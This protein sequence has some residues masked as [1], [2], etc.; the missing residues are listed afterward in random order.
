M[1]DRFGLP[2]STDVVTAAE[3]CVEGID[4]LLEQSYGPEERFQQTLEAD[5]SFALAHALT[6]FMWNQRG[7]AEEARQ[8][9]AQAQTLAQGVSRRETGIIEAMSLWVN[10]K[11]PQALP[12]AKEHLAEYPRDMI[13][14][15][16]ANRLFTLG[17][18]GAGVPDFPV[19]LL[20]MVKSIEKANGD[21]WSFL[22][23]SSFAHHEMGLLDESLRLAEGSLRFRPSNAVAAH[24]TAHV[25]FERGDHS[26]GNDFLGSWLPGFDKRAP[27]HVH[28]SWHQALF[29]L[30][31]GHYQRASELY[32]ADIRPSVTEKRATALNDSASLMW[33]MQ[34]YGG[35][36]APFPWH[37]V[38]DL[39]AP[40]ATGPG[41]AFRDAH[42]ALAFAGSGDD[43]SLGRL[44]DRLRTAGEAGSPLSSQ[45]TL[46]LAKG[47][48]AFAHGEY[49]EAV[50]Q[51]EPV[52]P[53]LPR[54]G[55]SH[56]QREV[57]EDTFLEACLRAEE[58]GKA[59][60]MLR[61]R[62]GTRGS[63]RDTF[64][65]ARL[66]VDTGQQ[67]KAG[68]NL[69]VVAQDWHNADS[70]SPELG[71]LNDLSERVQSSK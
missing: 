7:Q 46:P 53:Q 61:A 34:M 39:A 50:A 44:L 5:E 70:D 58:Y 45:V 63:T 37:E 11:G 4:L 29:E 15:R 21:E 48:G 64:R 59:E 9:A 27:Y 36:S 32:E 68:A 67:D 18:N 1:E 66:Q 30:A 22:G 2:I 41:P 69:R 33:R 16:I 40:A 12:I 35:A 60:N 28:L 26:D 23:L 47:I 25:Y 24:S 55:G 20:E 13:M 14:A 6:A 56:A 17:C 10:G 62:L 57:F 42:A 71:A 43:A 52:L 51:M 8:S 38:C 3:R 19:H 31:T 49:S 65:L 54:I